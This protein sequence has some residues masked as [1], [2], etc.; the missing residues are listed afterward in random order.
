MPARVLGQPAASACSSSSWSHISL[1]PNTP[2]GVVP[3]EG[4][5]QMLAVVG[6]SGQG[7]IGG[8]SG[9]AGRHGCRRRSGAARPGSRRGAAARRCSCGRLEVLLGAPRDAGV[10]EQLAQQGAAAA[11]VAQTR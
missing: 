9:G 3:G 10:L 2:L 1:A 8:P 7:R 5:V 6:Q 4:P 11:G